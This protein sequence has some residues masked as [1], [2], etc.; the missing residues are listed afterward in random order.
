MGVHIENDHARWLLLHYWVR[1]LLTPPHLRLRRSILIVIH[2][3]NLFSLTSLGITTDEVAKQALAAHLDEARKA[4]AVRL[5]VRHR[6]GASLTAIAGSVRLSLERGRLLRPI[7]FKVIIFQ[8]GVLRATDLGLIHRLR[9]TFRHQIA[10]I[11]AHALVSTGCVA[12]E[13]PLLLRLLHRWFPLTMLRCNG[14]AGLV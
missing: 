7:L 1:P 14:T 8:N 5:L 12:L 6:T 2:I 3:V 4:G 9:L 11:M 13:M 10:P